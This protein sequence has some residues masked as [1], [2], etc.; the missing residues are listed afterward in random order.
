MAEI[1]KATVAEVGCWVEGS[2]GRFGHTRLIEIAESRGW[3][4]VCQ[5]DHN[6]IE[7][8]DGKAECADVADC[9]CPDVVLGQG[10]LADKAEAWLN[11][12]VAPKGYQFG[13]SDGEFFLWSDGDWHMV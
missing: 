2:R 4:G 9:S 5:D 13:W 12:H 8:Y 11:E 3:Q 7:C 1:V 6:A 10:G